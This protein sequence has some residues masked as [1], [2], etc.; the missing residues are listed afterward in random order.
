VE[1]H[2]DIAGVICKT[3]WMMAIAAAKLGARHDTKKR[4]VILDYYDPDK[5]AWL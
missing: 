3:A 4:C 5:N 1:N 2:W